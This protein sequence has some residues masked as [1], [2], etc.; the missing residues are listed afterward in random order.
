MISTAC[1]VIVNLINLYYPELRDN[2][3]SAASPMIVHGR[4]LK[5]KYGPQTGVI[6]IGPCIAKKGEVLE[7]A[8]DH[9]IDCA[10]TFEELDEWMKREE[11]NYSSTR[12]D[13]ADPPDD[14]LEIRSEKASLY[15]L[16]G[17]MIQTLRQE[18]TGRRSYH[19][20]GIYRVRET[21]D[22]ILL[23]LNDGEDAFFELLSCAGGCINGPA[24]SGD[25]SYYRKTAILYDKLENR[26]PFS[27]GET[28]LVYHDYRRSGSLEQPRFSE[29]EIE[30]ALIGLDKRNPPD[31]RLNCGGCGYNSCRDFAIAKLQGKAEK[32]MC[33][34][35]MRKQAQKKVN[36]LDQDHSRGS[37]HCG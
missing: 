30:A 7:E 34:G 10:L 13:S 26:H 33:A 9:A 17:G 1:P 27:G 20:S 14:F 16:D 11:D 5:E 24:R 31:D 6:F 18:M 12:D 4:Y 21:L 25:Q 19:V 22:E 29:E 8:E 35:N 28:P 15:P 32:E 2:M 23:S 3:T 36:A 37:R